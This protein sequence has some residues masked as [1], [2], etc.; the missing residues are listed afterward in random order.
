MAI[1]DIGHSLHIFVKEKSMNKESNISDML[2]SFIYLQ[3]IN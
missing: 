1:V 2:L 3:Q